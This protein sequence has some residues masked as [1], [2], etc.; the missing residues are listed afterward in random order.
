MTA[1]KQ[2]PREAGSLTFYS[3]WSVGLIY[4]VLASGSSALHTRTRGS[5]DNSCFSLR[6]FVK[7]HTVR[8]TLFRCKETAC[9]LLKD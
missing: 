7:E 5:V 8:S 1:L 9:F 4:E 2:R 3:S 6:V